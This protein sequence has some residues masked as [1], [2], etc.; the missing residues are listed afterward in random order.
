MPADDVGSGGIDQV[1]VVYGLGV[2]E[3]E[4][5]N[6]AVPLLILRDQNLECDKPM[7]VNRLG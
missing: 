6:R 1:P 5:E 7:L 3:V 2:F 4:A